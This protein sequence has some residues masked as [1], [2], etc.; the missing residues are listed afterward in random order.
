MK[1]FSERVRLVFFLMVIWLSIS[2]AS[3]LVILSGASPEA[4][5]FWRLTLSLPFLYVMGIIRE[6]NYYP[7]IRLRHLIAGLSLSLHFVLWMH[8]LFSIPVYVSTLLVTLYPLY[9]LLIELVFLR[10]RIMVIQIMGFSL[11]TLLLVVYLDVSELV[12]NIGTLEALIA[13]ILASIYFEIGG[14]ARCREKESTLSYALSTYM[15]ASISTL[16]TSLLTNTQIVYTDYLKYVYFILLAFIPMILGHTLMNYLLGKYPA[17]IVTSISYGE[18]FGAGLL[19]YLLLGQVVDYR[20]VLFGSII[21]AITF[22]TVT[23][24]TRKIE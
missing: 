22:I 23:Y 4:C 7:R 14:Y 11:C 24:S 21:I 20:H 17:S 6:N 5:A 16:I 3:V 15:V 9:S 8:S 18:P 13:G 1:G 12:L 19:A 2:S 10:R